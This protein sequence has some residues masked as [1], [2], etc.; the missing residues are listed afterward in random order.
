MADRIRVTCAPRA[1]FAG[2]DDRRLVA[3]A[4]DGDGRAFEELVARHQPRLA[5]LLAR[6]IRDPAEAEDAMQE[7][8]LKAY[9]AFG[10]FRGDSEF[11]T[12]L[13][14]IAVNTAK[15][16]LLALSRRPP[17]SGDLHPDDDEVEDNT[18]TRDLDTPEG[19]LQAK[20]TAATVTRTLE[21]LPPDLR[22]AIELREGDIM[23]Y[24][25]IARE[26]HC[27]IGTVRSRIFRARE[28]IAHELARRG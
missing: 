24:E 10:N 16:Q 26:M 22:I 2:D 5:R 8:L 6:L 4:Q 19:V 15:N 9:R 11:Y 13:Y 14:R 7:S 27:P 28:A 3:L 20:Q 25:D 21:R 12:W 18:L 17:S 23:C 1:A